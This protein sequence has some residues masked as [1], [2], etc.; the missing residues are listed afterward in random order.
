MSRAISL[1]FTKRACGHLEV[2]PA[3]VSLHRRVRLS[4]GSWWCNTILNRRAG[5][6]CSR[7]DYCS[8]RVGRRI[9][10]R[11]RPRRA[12]RV[13]RNA[14]LR[15]RHPQHAYPLFLRSTATRS[16][17]G[18]SKITV[19]GGTPPPGDQPT[20]TH[21]TPVFSSS[22]CTKSGSRDSLIA[23]SRLSCV[24][25]RCAREFCRRAISVWSLDSGWSMLVRIYTSS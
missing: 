13:H 12:M 9:R 15:Q 8:F 5:R 6:S 25:L 24:R 21:I 2:D 23:S 14:F 18:V 17:R 16:S 1:L 20:I 3:V 11:L 4:F 7:S 19:R 22:A 10:R